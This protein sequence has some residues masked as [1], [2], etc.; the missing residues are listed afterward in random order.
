MSF[1]N[2]LTIDALLCMQEAEKRGAACAGGKHAAA[3]LTPL[4]MRVWKVW[5]VRLAWKSSLAVQAV[6][7]QEICQGCG[8]PVCIDMVP[9]PRAAPPPRPA[10]AISHVQ[11]G[12]RDLS[13]R[14][15]PRWDT[16]PNC[17]LQEW[18]VI[19]NA[20]CVRPGAS[21]ANT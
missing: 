1:Y 14:S 20:G 2:M 3:C 13:L 9:N 19:R 21:T 8:S 18:Q 5:R 10:Q 7:F 16:F 6:S 4:R 17:P 15:S 11:E 12:P